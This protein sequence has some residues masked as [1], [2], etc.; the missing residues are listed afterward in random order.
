MTRWGT[1]TVNVSGCLLLGVLTGVGLDHGLVAST[2][3]VLGTAGLGTYLDA[4]FRNAA[5]FSSASR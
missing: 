2:R 3:T 1:F 4:T 5:T